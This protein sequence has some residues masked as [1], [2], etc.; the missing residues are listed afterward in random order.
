M[1]LPL[2]TRQRAALVFTEMS[3]SLS[4]QAATKRVV[5]ERHLGG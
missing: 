5:V 2:P 4:D 1:L 3:G